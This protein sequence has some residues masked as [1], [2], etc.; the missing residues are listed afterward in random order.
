MVL[1]ALLRVLHPGSPST[2][3]SMSDPPSPIV[4]WSSLLVLLYKAQTGGHSAL[5][6]L[7]SALCRIWC[8]CQDGLHESERGNSPRTASACTPK[9]DWPLCVP[10]DGDL[11]IQESQL[12]ELASLCTICS[13]QCLAQAP[14]GIVACRRLYGLL[15]AQAHPCQALVSVW[16]RLGQPRVWD[17]GADVCSLWQV[18]F[19]DF[20]PST[21]LS[22]LV[23]QEVWRVVIAQRTSAP[24][25]SFREPWSCFSGCSMLALGLWEFKA[26]KL[27]C[28]KAALEAGWKQGEWKP[29]GVAQDSSRCL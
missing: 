17:S 13:Q 8:L 9:G 24:V 27:G 12:G 1:S 21:A 19:P 11:G 28:W 2:T 22:S 7:P 18:E 5:Y 3:E 6:S 10:Q 26:N 15:T 25:L 29:G 4:G 14:A 23:P 20:F 16:E